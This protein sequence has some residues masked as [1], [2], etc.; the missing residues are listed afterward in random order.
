MTTPERDQARFDLITF[1]RALITNRT[2]EAHDIAQRWGL[3]DLPPLEVSTAL[4]EAATLG[5]APADSVNRGME[6][7]SE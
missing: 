5:V 1:H 4:M 7:V 6:G 3:Q 2:K